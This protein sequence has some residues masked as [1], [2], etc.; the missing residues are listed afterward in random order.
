MTLITGGLLRHAERSPAHPALEVGGRR[1]SYGTLAAAIRRVA[2]GLGRTGE[3]TA[4]RSPCPQVTPPRVGLISS[5]RP[6]FLEV[7]LGT[8]LAG[9]QTTVFDPAWP[10]MTLAAE[11]ARSPLDLLFATPEIIGAAGEVLAPYRPIAFGPDYA[12]WRDR[13]PE[14]PG[15]ADAPKH[16]GEPK[17]AR[18]PAATEDDPPFY[19][20][21][22]SG[23]TGRP[24]AFHRTHSSWLHSFTASARELGT[25]AGDVVLAPGPLAHSLTL[26]AA[27]EALAAGATIDLLPRFDATAALERLRQGA[28]TVLVAVPTVLMAI[29][30]AAGDGFAAN[31]ALRAVI[32]SGAKLAPALLDRLAALFPRA[33]LIEYYGASELSFVALRSSRAGAPPDSVGRPFAGVEVSIRRPDGSEAAAGETGLLWVRSA[34]VC[35]GYADPV[36]DT[37]FRTADGWATVGDHAWRD[38][39]GWLYLAGREQ[40]MII[41]G[42]LN[43]YPAEIEAVLRRLP[44][45]ADAAVVGMPDPYWGEQVCGVLALAAAASPT[46]AE[47]QAHCRVALAGHKVPRRVLVAAALPLTPSGKV[48][49]AELRRRVAAADP[50][51]VELG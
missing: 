31:P 26:Y 48:A 18:P 14:E 37:G 41:S 51:L 47:I 5:N 17:A 43:L 49:R 22:T 36:D 21:F 12:A 16:P 50:A 45:V 46:L 42:G 13:A 4:A 32:S 39:A 3:G 28:H 6:E 23:T 24:K 20:G 34:M 29:A 7:F 40:D 2:A 8:A 44:G 1:H 15:P 30:A 19:A 33:E 10:P 38:A 25:H 35:S 9:G 11:L 27:V